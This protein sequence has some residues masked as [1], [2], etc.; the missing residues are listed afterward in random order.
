MADDA[1]IGHA[2]ARRL[3]A[4]ALG[5]LAVVGVV[6]GFSLSSTLAKRA[7]TRGALLAFWRLT[8]AT[9]VFNLYLLSTGRRVTFRDV[10]VAI[11]P[12]VFFGLNLAT[13]F[14]GATNNSVANAALI[15]SLSP[16]LI[17]PLGA[18]VFGEYND[19]R[20]L[21]FALMSFGGV[22]FVLLNA[23]PLGDGSAKGNVLGFVAML[24]LVAYVVSTRYFRRSMDVAVFM[25]TICPIA[26]LAVLPIALTTGD[27]LGMSSTG[28]T[29]ML[30]LTFLA[31][32]AA[33]G[34]LVYAQKAIA[35]GTIAISQVVQP[36]IALVW[37]FLLL[38]E[39]VRSRQALGIAVAMAGLAA[40]LVL[41]QRGERSERGSTPPQG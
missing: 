30:L 22:A 6:V 21:V 10:R 15:G 35:I 41:N 36:A 17:V 34:L 40:F 28:W 39:T 13:F 1:G 20:A 27:G 33:N 16:F 24:L 9:G 31:G 2:Q 8:V 19:R 4:K 11:V 23:P 32:V 5:A 38:G 37:S 14:V 25:A 12:G 18:I 29:Y 3:G 26:A 7:E